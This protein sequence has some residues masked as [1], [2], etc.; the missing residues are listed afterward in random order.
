MNVLPENHPLLPRTVK[1]SRSVDG[2]EKTLEI[3]TDANQSWPLPL[4]LFFTAAFLAYTL[5]LIC[6]AR[7]RDWVVFFLGLL[8]D[9]FVLQSPSFS[10]SSDAAS[11]ASPEPP[12]PPSSA[13]APSAGAAASPS[14]KSRGCASV[15]STTWATPGTSTTIRPE[16]C[17]APAKNAS[18]STVTTTMALSAKSSGT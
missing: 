10:I 2:G 14:R 18:A 15:G 17:S 6:L 13:S 11:S 8:V 1:V 3:E 7:D 9:V 16:F 5:V 4:A 12:E